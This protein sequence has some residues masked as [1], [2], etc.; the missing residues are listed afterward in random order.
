MSIQVFNLIKL[1]I[2][3]S[4]DVSEIILAHVRFITNQIFPLSSLTYPIA[5]FGRTLN[6]TQPS[7]GI[8]GHFSGLKDSPF[9]SMEKGSQPVHRGWST[10]KSPNHPTAKESFPEKQGLRK[11]SKTCAKTSLSLSLS[12]FASGSLFRPDQWGT[13]EV[14][15]AC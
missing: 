8:K 12:F 5:Q 9:P 2:V 1:Q 14:G 13:L 15:A 3:F 11:G 4:T 6:P 7:A 10:L